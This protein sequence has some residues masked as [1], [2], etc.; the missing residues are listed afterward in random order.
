MLKINEEQLEANAKFQFDD[1]YLKCKNNFEEIYQE[2]ANGIK[3]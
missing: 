1:H 3:K 2:K